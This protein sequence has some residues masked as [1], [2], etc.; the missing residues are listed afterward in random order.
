MKFKFELLCADDD[1]CELEFVVV[2]NSIGNN[3]YSEVKRWDQSLAGI[4]E[5]TYKFTEDRWYELKWLFARE[6]VGSHLRI[7]SITLTNV[8]NAGAIGFQ[9][10]PLSVD[11]DCIPCPLGHYIN[12]P[13][14]VVVRDHVKAKKS[15]QVDP[16]SR[17]LKCPEKTIVNKSL[18]FPI[19]LK[20]SCIPCGEGLV[21]SDDRTECYNQCNLTLEGD[22][23]NLDAIPAPIR[24]KGIPLFSTSGVGYYHDYKISLCGFTKVTCFNNMT[25]YVFGDNRVIKSYICRSTIVQKKS[26][27]QSIS[28]G[29]EILAVTKEPKFKNMTVHPDFNATKHDV[30]LYFSLKQESNFCPNGRYSIVTLRCQTDLDQDYTVL[31]P[32]L[33]LDGSCDGCVFHFMVIS[34]T[35]ATCKIC[36]PKDFKKVIGECIN[37]RQR[38]HYI[39]AEKCIIKIDKSFIQS[40]ACSTIPRSAKI[41]IAFI[42]GVGLLLL[43][44]V[45]HFWKVN[46]K[47]EYKYSKLIEDR[48][49]AE[50]CAEDDEE[51]EVRVRSRTSKLDSSDYET[52][53]LTKHSSDDII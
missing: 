41:G 47:L 52:I 27:S 3:R 43:T 11:S 26:S 7:Y 4:R 8:I 17:C 19:G 38:I 13:D 18:A 2:K 9:P 24:M 14:E 10:C 50:C 25:D 49:S 16:A 22:Q 21:S 32:K 35:M 36:R 39:G 29:D 44:L 40:R 20:S 6:A 51:E 23:Y 12:L 37:G 33:C 53:Q 48:N 30:H 42:S 46:R 28:L 31:T 1:R 15:Q 34:R 5:Y 45:L